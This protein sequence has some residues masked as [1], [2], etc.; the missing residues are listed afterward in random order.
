MVDA[1][2]ICVLNNRLIPIDEQRGFHQQ[3]EAAGV[4]STFICFS[5]PIGHDAFLVDIDSM[6]ELV[7]NYLSRRG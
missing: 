3:L 5:S 4:D 6:S 7:S 1:L 2:P